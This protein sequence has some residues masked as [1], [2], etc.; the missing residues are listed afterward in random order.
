[1]CRI[2]EMNL[3]RETSAALSRRSRKEGVTLH[4][5]LSAAL[6]KAVHTHLYDGSGGAFRHFF[7]TDLR[8]YLKP[9]VEPGLLGSY[10][11]L[12]RLTIPLESPPDIWDL[13]RT[14]QHLIQRTLKRGDKFFV[15][16]TTDMM[17]RMILRQKSTRMG[18]TG[19]SYTIPFDQPERSEI[20]RLLNIH[21]YSS[22]FVM[23]PEYTAFVRLFQGK[24]CWDIVYLD[25]DM[26]GEKAERIAGDIRSI[27]QFSVAE[28]Q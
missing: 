15:N 28:A 21:A 17:M 25:S 24:L 13:A 10:F 14:F 26:D 6:I 11:S 22:N 19:L 1:M 12:M 7:T 2:L 16:L 23:G 4:S 8:P 18:T 9:A 27:L 5:I 3:D 20:C